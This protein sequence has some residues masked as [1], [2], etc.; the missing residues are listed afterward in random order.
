MALESSGNF[1]YDKK[2]G[3]VNGCTLSKGRH[4]QK[5]R[6]ASGIAV[7]DH[8]KEKEEPNGTFNDKGCIQKPGRA[9]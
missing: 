7:H 3:Y 5:R 2:A 6:R 4:F 8:R 1:R 9:Y